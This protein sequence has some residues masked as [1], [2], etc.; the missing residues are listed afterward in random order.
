MFFTELIVCAGHAGA[1]GHHGDGSEEDYDD[2]PEGVLDED[3]LHGEPPA[4]VAGNAARTMDWLLGKAL[5]Q[6]HQASDDEEEEVA[7]GHVLEP[8]T[9][10]G[11]AFPPRGSVEFH[12]KRAID[13]FK[14]NTE[15]GSKGKG[16]DWKRYVRFCHGRGSGAAVWPP[17]C[18]DW[19]DFLVELRPQVRSFPRFNS[20]I[21][22]ICHVGCRQAAKDSNAWKI[23]EFDP[24]CL[25]AVA[26]RAMKRQMKRESGVEVKQ[27]PGI[28]M[29]EARSAVNYIDKWSLLGCCMGIAWTMG[30][31]M[32]GRR[33]RTLASV[34]LQ[35]IV[36]EVQAIKVQRGDDVESHMYPSIKSV[37]FTDEKTYAY[38]GDRMASDNYAGAVFP[39]YE[40]MY[41]RP[42]YWI[43]RFLVMRAV[44]SEVDPVASGHV[45]KTFSARAECM[46][47]YLMCQ[48]WGEEWV[49]SMPVAPYT[50]SHWNRKLLKRMGCPPRGFSSHRRGCA[51]RALALSVFKSKGAGVD[52]ATIEVI[53]RWGGWEAI[54]GA[55]TVY[56]V[57][58][59]PILDTCLD[60]AALGLGQAPSDEHLETRYLQFMGCITHPS[61]VIVEKGRIM[62]PLRFR[63]MVWHDEDVAMHRRNVT[64]C[65]ASILETAA[66]D[67]NLCPVRR[68]YSPRRL[69]NVAMGHADYAHRV[70]EYR[71][72]RASYTTCMHD[73]RS[74]LAREVTSQVQLMMR[75]RTYIPW[76]EAIMPVHLGGTWDREGIPSADLVALCP[77][78]L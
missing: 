11:A 16:Y 51:T 42:A 40:D 63:Y 3:D 49:G 33:S 61:D 20:A 45:G 62:D 48:C 23:G 4:Y 70:M 69:L 72:C 31:V 35:D 1:A 64:A 22:N 36:L 53:T 57:Y 5:V 15:Q 68:F 8:R 43:Y 27:V 65:V 46:E 78:R 26:H 50:L 55:R 54:S 32:G 25:Y 6:A 67:T 17:T 13:V 37:T 2:V 39:S 24:R 56:K 73:K 18:D 28:T 76:T 9:K 66:A 41:R 29:E 74:M 30:C 77:L 52:P 58:T 19:L 44:F 38:S 21:D 47:E 71:R 34:R 59:G 7:I 10:R 60:G 75:F 14:G 12:R